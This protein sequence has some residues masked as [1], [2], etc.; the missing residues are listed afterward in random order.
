M[1]TTVLSEVKGLVDKRFLLSSFFPVLLFA[2]GADLLIAS[3]HRGIDNQIKSWNGYSGVVQAIIAVGGLAA[4]LLVAAVV[5]S[6][7]ILITQL[8][9][10][11]FGPKML[12]DRWT[13]HQDE[14]KTKTPGNRELRFPTNN[15]QPTALGNVLRAAEEYP[16]R[17]YG[18]SVV[19][20][21][22]RLFLVLP[23][24]LLLSA[25]GPADTIQF[26]LN[27]SLLATMFAVLGGSYAAFE[28]LGAASYVAALVGGVVVARLAYRGAV[29]AAI[30]YGL[31][32]RGAFDL[33]R[34]DL[35]LKLRWA[36]PTSRDEELRTWRDVSDRLR[37]GEPKPVR[38]VAPPT[39]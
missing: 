13:K 38:Y 7:S 26:L 22:P 30:A 9:E 5:S 28:S 2:F 24:E 36:M 21:W 15:L 34:N 20:V 6:C 19:V 10:G 14:R 33:H 4:V 18:A 35:L 31:H 25:S 23:A 3:A 12:K 32:I 11:Y 8:Y 17:A 1:L 29:E 27:T 16:E 37:R 39:K